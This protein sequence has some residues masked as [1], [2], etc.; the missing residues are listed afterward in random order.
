MD[1]RVGEVLDNKR[2][3][4]GR[5]IDLAFER[6]GIELLAPPKRLG[7]RDAPPYHYNCYVC[8]GDA[9]WPVIGFFTMDGVFSVDELAKSEN[10]MDIF[11]MHFEQIGI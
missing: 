4:E 2:V 8:H 5:I 3:N 7:P 9:H 11:E 6:M 1:T 10:L